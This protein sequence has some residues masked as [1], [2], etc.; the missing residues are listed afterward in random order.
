MSTQKEGT[1]AVAAAVAAAPT[2]PYFSH[3]SW[4]IYQVKIAL[5]T[6]GSESDMAKSKALQ[7]NLD[8]DYVICYRFAKTG[9]FFWCMV[10]G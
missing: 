8:V 6:S 1:A 10:G 4:T 3:L 7:T 9:M 5:L 2:I